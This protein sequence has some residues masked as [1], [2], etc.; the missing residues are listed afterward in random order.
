M[1]EY[2]VS[3]VMDIQAESRD[4]AHEKLCTLLRSLPVQDLLKAQGVTF[5]FVDKGG[6]VESEHFGR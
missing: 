6:T 5:W 2:Q 3:V 1:E 4:H